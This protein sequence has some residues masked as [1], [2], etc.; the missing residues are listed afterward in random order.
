MYVGVDLNKIK[1]P[2]SRKNFYTI[3]EFNFLENYD[4]L[5]FDYGLFD[6][7]VNFEVYEHMD[8]LSGEKLLKG[9][10][11]TLEDDGMLI[12]ST[13]VYCSS[14]KQANNH[15]NEVTKQEIEN[16]L[17]SAGFKIIKQFGTFCNQNDL[18]KVA[19]PNEMLLQK[20]LGGFYGNELL[21]CFLSPKYPEAS[22][23]IVHIC[24]KEDNDEHDACTLIDSVV[25]FNGEEPGEPR[26]K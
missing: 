7:I 13:P 18:R 6:L 8:F 25:K 16:E 1:N 21:G 2:I 5:G 9:M 22:R 24:V 12:F 15:I 23:N 10:Y 14:Y 3:D 20:T 26:N 4:D 19:T 11:E 17:Q